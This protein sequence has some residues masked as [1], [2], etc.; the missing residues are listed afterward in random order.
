[1]RKRKPIAK[2][3]AVDHYFVRALRRFE[4]TPTK[5]L[6]AKPS[7]HAD[8]NPEVTPHHAQTLQVARH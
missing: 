6:P 3:Y 8:E 4:S 2:C 1:M 5:A 7:T